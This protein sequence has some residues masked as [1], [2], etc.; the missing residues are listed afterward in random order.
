MEKLTGT[1]FGIQHF[2]I[3]DGHGVRT[4]VFFKGCPIR[5]VWCHNPE[6]IGP[7]PLLA[8]SAAKCVGC[9]ACFTL[10]PS[11]HRMFGG[12]HVL[13]RD[14]CAACFRCVEACPG[15]ALE[16]VGAR[17]TVDE[18]MEDVL[19]DMRYYRASGGG[20][21]LSGGEPMMQFDFAAALLEACREHQIGTAL[22]TCGVARREQYERILPLVDTFLYDIKES[23]PARHREFTGADNAVI[24]SNLAYL[25]EHGARILLRCP[26]I[27]RLNDREEH[28]VYLAELSKR[29]RGVEGIELMPYHK[30]G[31]S[32]AGRMGLAPQAAFDEPEAGAADRWNEII[33][34]AGGHV[35]V[36]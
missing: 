28:L 4:N 27:P 8:Y 32:K 9:G 17:M 29:H 10:C 23:D 35:M 11:V 15:Q 5:C 18:V 14:A 6:G 16:Q 24:L 34:A 25:S 7:D 21:T 31:T 22:E 20:V 13:D 12:A 1:I 26:I 30:L 33:R 3:H 19:R 36:Y 2:S